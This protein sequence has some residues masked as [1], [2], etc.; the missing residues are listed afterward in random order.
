[1]ALYEYRCLKCAKAFTVQAKMNDAPPTRG[2]SCL[3]ESCDLQKQMSRVFGQV[4]GRTPAPPQA[5][6]QTVEAPR[7]DPIHV[8]SKYCDHHAKP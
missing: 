4:A 6:A 5:P 7:E 1:M 8:C 2:P 3:Q